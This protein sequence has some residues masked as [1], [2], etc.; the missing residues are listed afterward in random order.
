MKNPTHLILDN[1]SHP[2]ISLFWKRHGLSIMEQLVPNEFLFSN[3]D[4]QLEKIIEKEIWSGWKKLILIG[5]PTS[6]RRGFNTI[7]LASPECR[8]TLKLGFW[9]INFHKFVSFMSKSPSNLRPILQVFKAGHTLNVDVPKVQF[10]APK[11]ETRF[12]W[13]DFVINSTQDSAETNFFIDEQNTHV[14]GKFS[15]QIAFHEEVLDS[16]TMHPG[17]LSRSPILKVFINKDNSLTSPKKLTKFKNWFSNKKLT[18]EK[19]TLLKTGKQIEIQ[20]SWANLSLT[21]PGIQDTVESVHFEVERKSFPLIISAK[22][23]QTDE[24]IRNYLP[25]FHPSRVIANNR[26]NKDF[27]DLKSRKFYQI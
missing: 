12:F 10:L 2:A 18:N 8:S 27:L 13:N 16:L 23:I 20:G 6:I 26:R 15:S 17:K 3:G 4:N 19:E 25:T 7:M 5:T 22:P 21:L 14:S 1:Y 24:S 9:P 11:L